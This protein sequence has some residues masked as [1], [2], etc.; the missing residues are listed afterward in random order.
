MIRIDSIVMGSVYWGLMNQVNI[1]VSMIDI[2]VFSDEY[3]YIKIII[4]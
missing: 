2:S 4:V 3:F 1:G